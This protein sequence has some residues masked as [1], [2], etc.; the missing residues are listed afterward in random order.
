[1]CDFFKQNLHIE[2]KRNEKIVLWYW[3]SG[4]VESI[5]VKTNVSKT[6][7]ETAFLMLGATP[8]N[9]DNLK[10]SRAALALETVGGWE[11]V[12]KTCYLCESVVGSGWNIIFNFYY[13]SCMHWA[14]VFGGT[15]DSVGIYGDCKCGLYVNIAWY[16]GYSLINTLFLFG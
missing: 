6:K 11:I 16:I 4:V 12:Q 7:K 8:W 5:E 9:S 13:I 10:I 1:M 2:M 3:Q 14:A 15:G